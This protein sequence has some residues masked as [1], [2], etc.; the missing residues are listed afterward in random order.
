MNGNS[1]HSSQQQLFPSLNFDDDNEFQNL[2]EM[3]EGGEYDLPY[4]FWDDGDMNISGMNNS[5]EGSS[6]SSAQKDSSRS[7]RKAIPDE[8]SQ[9]NS[10]LPAMALQQQMAMS[11]SSNDRNT[12]GTNNQQPATGNNDGGANLTQTFNGYSPQLVNPSIG[13]QPFI[14]PATLDGS[15]VSSSVHQA[16]LSNN[17]LNSMKPPP[18][19]QQVQL[20]RPKE[21]NV[22]AQQQQQNVVNIL[23]RMPDMKSTQSQ[24]DQEQQAQTQQQAQAQQQAQQQQQAQAQQQA[25]QQ[26]QAQAQQAQVQQ[27]AQA[28]QQFQGNLF[29]LQNAFAPQQLAAAWQT[30]ANSMQNLQYLQQQLQAGNPFLNNGLLPGSNQMLPPQQMMQ[31]HQMHLQQQQAQAQQQQQQAQ[32][33]QA[34]QQAQQQRVQQMQQQ[35]LQQQAQQRAQQAQKEQARAQAQVQMQQQTNPEKKQQQAELLAKVDSV[36]A[37]IDNIE[38]HQRQQLEEKQKQSQ[39]QSRQMYQQQ[40][41]SQTQENNGSTSQSRNGPSNNMGQPAPRPST[42]LMTPSQSKVPQLKTNIVSSSDTD[43]E[44]SSRPTPMTT[45]KKRSTATRDNTSLKAMKDS[46]FSSLESDLKKK[47]EDVT[48]EERNAE[49]R[50]R[51]REHARNT[52]ARKKAYLESLKTTLDELCR[53]RDSLVSERAGAASLLLEV[54]KTRIDVLLSFFALRSS[55]EKRRSLWSSI[56]DESFNC[57]IPVTPYRS[58]PASEVQISKCQRTIMGIDGMIA[59]TA[60]MHVLLNSLVDRSRYPN[61][62]IDFRYTLIAEEAIVSGSQM[63]ARWSMTTTNATKL[64]AKR[65]IKKMGMLCAKFSSAHKI[66][67]L[68]LMFDVMAFMLQLKQCAGVNAFTVVPN[69]VQTCIGPFGNSPMVMTLADRPYTIVQVNQQWEDMTGWKYEEVV[70][71]K[72]CKILQ[73]EETES[74]SIGDMMNSINYQRP[75]FNVLTNY[76]KGEKKMFR[77]FIN[78]YPLSTDSEITHYVGLTIHIEWLDDEKKTS[79]KDSAGPVQ[80][81]PKLEQPSTGLKATTSNELSNSGSGPTKVSLSI[82]E[83]D[84][85]SSGNAFNSES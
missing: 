19:Q 59:D 29:N 60:S 52:R 38:E 15:N 13:L 18:N 30:N 25:Q 72:S 6:H 20:Q 24:G 23:P 69:T 36:Q 14:L 55:Y 41:I 22:N 42:N 82:D 37:Q 50:K 71:K 1:N 3:G 70:G 79:Q 58:F 26:Q 16:Q 62:K 34:Q 67:A 54:Q 39:N 45:L 27:Q 43:G 40:N 80:V 9:T 12:N 81:K 35:Q 32:Q 84:S 5:E 76:T 8:A 57:V 17:F 28:Q 83:S 78:L 53:E 51:N 47:D 77:N 73:G 7:S 65:E 75:A 66:V 85:R 11:Y 2:A 56:L 48:D 63:M 49:N 31:P 44:H 33:R 21:S 68:E 46:S 4:V 61:G 74:S 64:G 10:S